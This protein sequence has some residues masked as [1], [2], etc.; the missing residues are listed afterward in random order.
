MAHTSNPAS[1]YLPRLSNG[2][3]TKLLNSANLT[4]AE[5][6]QLRIAYAPFDYVNKAARLVIVGI[7]PGETQAVAAIQQAQTALKT[8]ATEAEALS[9]AKVHASFSGGM[10]NSLIAMLDAIGVAEHFG[11]SSTSELFSHGSNEVHFTSALRYPVFRKGKNYNGAPDM[12]RTPL[13]RQILDTHL[14]D[15]ARQLPDALWLPL[16]PKADAA[17][18]YIRDQGHLS[19][20]RILSGL[21]HPSGANA[22]R[23]AVFLGRKNPQAASKQTNGLALVEAR[24]RLAAQIANLKGDVQ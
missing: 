2:N 23:I 10:R 3:P 7:T 15:E 14:V 4:I 13:L 16:G 9:R 6:G 1:Q 17:L 20:G 22:E 19:A 12:I 24:A 21:P 8:G 18:A 11:L 5:Q